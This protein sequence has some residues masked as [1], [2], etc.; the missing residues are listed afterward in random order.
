MIAVIGSSNMDIV[1]NVDHFTLPGETQKAHS[2]NFYFGGK[3]ANQTIAVAKLSKKNV[4]F[5]SCLGDDEYGKEIAKNFENFNIEGYNI[6]KKELT[7]RAYIEVDKK[8]ENRIILFTGANDKI[9]KEKIDMFLNKYQNK[10]D[11]CLLQNEIPI[12]SVEYAISRLHEKGIKIVYD[13]APV[14]NTNVGIL[15]KV[16]FLTPNETEFRFLCEKISIT[17]DESKMDKA[18]I[19]FKEITKVKNLIVKLGDNGCVYLD[20]N[21]KTEKVSG[22][23]VKAIDTTAAGDIFNGAF[24]VAYEETNDL[25]KSL[26]FANKAAAISVTRKGAQS[27]IPGREEVFNFSF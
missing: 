26:N 23:K 17:F 9:D 22:I 11:V 25:I 2:L 3:G 8:G 4:Y 14:G 12:E 27:S 7:G 5:C 19:K 21:G 1:F 18:V 24:S 6:E 10:I 15:E 20:E 13:P 16:D